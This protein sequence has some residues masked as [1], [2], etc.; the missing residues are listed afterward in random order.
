MDPGSRVR[1]R[2]G[3]KG[4]TPAGCHG[5]D[6]ADVRAAYLDGRTI[7]TRVSAAYARCGSG[8]ALWR[9]VGVPAR[10]ATGQGAA[11]PTPPRPALP[12]RAVGPGLR[13]SSRL[14]PSRSIITHVVHI[15]WVVIGMES[16]DMSPQF[17]GAGIG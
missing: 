6:I 7:A 1:R 12:G 10:R 15:T 13:E 5:Q 3:S 9:A 4:R 8:D 2:R 16:C 17:G 14:L 11:R